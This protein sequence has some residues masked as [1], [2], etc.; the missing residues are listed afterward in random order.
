MSLR[1]SFLISLF[2]LL[3]IGTFL[4]QDGL[5][6]LPPEES[7]MNNLLGLGARAMGMGGAHI[8]VAE[9]FSALW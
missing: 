2:L 8:A 7:S 3:W 1:K 9:D 4:A 6:V 5:S